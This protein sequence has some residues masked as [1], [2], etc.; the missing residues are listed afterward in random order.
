MTEG[1]AG[2]LIVDDRPEKL[3]ALEA[4][5]E[6]L[7]QDI[8]RAYSGREALRQVLNHDFAVILLDV[9]MP[10][11]D[12]FE[13]ATL[14]RQRKS[15]EHT[16]IIFITAFGDEMNAAQGYS[17][18]AV[19]YI[20]APVIPEVLRTKVAVF[21]ELFTKTEQLKRQT[22]WLRNRADQ[23]H[24][25]TGA[26]LAINSALSVDQ[27]LRVVTQTARKIIGAHQAG[28]IATLG[29]GCNRLVRVSSFSEKFP[30]ADGCC[31]SMEATSAHR[32]VRESGAPKRLTQAEVEQL[33]GWLEAGKRL[34]VMFQRADGTIEPPMRG[35]LAAPLSSRDGNNMGILELSDRYEGDFTDD[36][37]AIVVQLAQMASIALE[38]SLYAEE[39]EANRIKDEFLAT[40]SHELRTPLNAIL[41]WT[42]L[43]RMERDGKVSDPQEVEHGLE[44]IERNARSQ[45]KLIEDLL[46]VSRITT[47]KM[48][49]N[50]KPMQI[51]PVVLAAADV[52]RPATEA[53]QIRLLC[54]MDSDVAG[55]TISGDP[56]RLQQVIW[57]L[58]SNAAKFTPPTGQIT[59]RLERQDEFVL[60]H[61][62]DTGKGIDP[63]FLPNVF[64]RFRQAD[65][66]STRTQGGLG[67]GLTIVRHIVEL[68]G[69]TVS[70][71]S[72]GDGKGA[73]FTVTLPIAAAALSAGE[74]HD[75]QGPT[76]NAVDLVS[77]AAITGMRIVIVD[78]EPD[79]R[80]LVREILTR[81]GAG[82]EA[83]ASVSEA[84]EM[85]QRLQPDVLVS[86]IAMPGEDGFELIRKLR[87]LPPESGG[88]TPAIA[89][90]AYAREDDR[91]HMLSCGFQ[92]HVAKPVE[93]SELLGVLSRWANAGH[94]HGA[95]GNGK[96][97]AA[98]SRSPA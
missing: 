10:G 35:W 33:A 3:L 85:I 42:Q 83:A 92:A 5:L 39:R 14:I 15:S 98:L 48:R 67:I 74:P 26:S 93:P 41:G 94:E 87:N 24:Q 31:G 96:T 43:L 90:T 27:M 9:N 73:T 34:P 18:G 7:G 36:D 56:D 19:D 50:I 1:K 53:K 59:C 77:A 66:S 65:S 57:N 47:G 13:T 86:D 81:A 62:T 29:P 84:M 70:A 8:F 60:L 51:G 12:G 95:N 79:A 17:L 40:L 89:L 46:D 16:P 76:R 78:D 64:D 20:L 68:H 75:K 21:V 25:L 91:R 63:K 6:D 69:G 49:L 54:Q 23:L 22:H 38:N 71:D 97:S 30:G 37:E 55:M 4:V 44:V 32:A 88:A 2:I 52:V 11:M 82:V 61:V 80:E 58:L 72:A 28:A 45:A